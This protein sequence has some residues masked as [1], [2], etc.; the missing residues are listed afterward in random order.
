MPVFLAVLSCLIALI[1]GCAN[2][3]ILERYSLDGIRL[4]ESIK[5]LISE[6]GKPTR[7][8]GTLYYWTSNNGETL[9]IETDA[10][11]YISVIDLKAGRDDTREVALPAEEPQRAVVLRQTAHVNYVPP[12][13]S[14]P[15][16]ENFCAELG[17]NG[18]PCE[19]YKLPG[20][21]LL[22]LN[23]G[24]DVGLSDGFLSEVMLSSATAFGSPR[25]SN[26]MKNAAQ[27]LRLYSQ[28]S[29]TPARFRSGTVEPA[30]AH[31]K[32]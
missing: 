27:L 11:G 32:R 1:A 21:A 9:E 12:R 4:G 13:G 23:F 8:L 29:T 30:L 20:G 19:S 16:V 18:K 2:R 10:G 5:Q 24:M 15:T 31:R 22:V 17:L 28:I 6:R 25:Q 26:R 7:D 3:S 14:E